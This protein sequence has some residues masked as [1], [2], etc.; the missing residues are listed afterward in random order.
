MQVW[1]KR[2]GG[3]AMPVKGLEHHRPSF[4]AIIRFI[5]RRPRLKH[6]NGTL[7]AGELCGVRGGFRLRQ[8]VTEPRLVSR[9]QLL[10]E[11]EYLIK[12]RHGSSFPTRYMQEWI[13]LC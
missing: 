10:R 5:S 3:L 11:F 2:T 8:G 9:S 7:I 4:V 12:G 13:V 6:G 1:I